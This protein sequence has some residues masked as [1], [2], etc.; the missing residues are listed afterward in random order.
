MYFLFFFFA[1]WQKYPL[2]L[3]IILLHID[4]FQSIYLNEIASNFTQQNK[5]I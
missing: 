5:M 4:S 2:N 3:A 1:V